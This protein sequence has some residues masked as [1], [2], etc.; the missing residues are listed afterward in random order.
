M[1]LNEPSIYYRSGHDRQQLMMFWADNYTQSE[2]VGFVDTDCVFLTYIDREDLFEGGKPVVN[3]RSGFH[4]PNDA[5]SKIPQSTYSATGILEPM[6]CMSYF[7]VIIKT[8]HFKDMREYIS[9]H[10]GK[11][12]NDVF[13]DIISTQG[14]CQFCIMVSAEERDIFACVYV[15]RVR[16]VNKS[17]RSR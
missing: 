2:Y 8:A 3:G 16:I 9:K 13:H 5:W 15:T 1:M 11:P 7:P 14:F 6:R 17:L 12:F 4:D 10:H